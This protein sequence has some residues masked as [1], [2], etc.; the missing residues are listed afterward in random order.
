[1]SDKKQVAS[2]RPYSMRNDET[3]ARYRTTG[4]SVKDSLGLEK[5]TELWNAAGLGRPSTKG[6]VERWLKPGPLS[7]NANFEGFIFALSNS[8]IKKKHTLGSDMTKLS[9]KIESDKFE[10]K[11]DKATAASLLAYYQVDKSLSAKQRELVSELLER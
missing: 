11:R 4:Q 6:T 2:Y 5:V 9:N 1:M 8:Q 7:K 3:K 10:S